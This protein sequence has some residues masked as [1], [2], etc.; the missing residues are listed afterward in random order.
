MDRFILQRQVRT[1]LT[2]YRQYGLLAL[3]RAVYNKISTF[4]RQKPIVPSQ[5]AMKSSSEQLLLCQQE[6]YRLTDFSKLE[7]SGPKITVFILGLGIYGE[8][9]EQTI[10]S[11]LNIKY[12]H[13]NAVL[14]TDDPQASSGFD[15]KFE[16]AYIGT[17]E[18]WKTILD[19]QVRDSHSEYIA[20]LQAGDNLTESSLNFV[21]LEIM[22]S[23]PEMIYSNYC[24]DER[25]AVKSNDSK[26]NWYPALSLSGEAI[27]HSLFFRKDTFQ[28]VQGEQ[29]SHLNGLFVNLT[30]SVLTARGSIRYIQQILMISKAREPLFEQ[31][32]VSQNCFEAIARSYMR[33][34][35]ADAA[36]IWQENKCQIRIRKEYNP[37]VSLI[38]YFHPKA[39]L[40]CRSINQLII[41]TEY[42]NLEYIFVVPKD[43]EE[44][45]RA[46]VCTK[47]VKIISCDASAT[48]A[49]A[50]NLAAKEANGDFLTFVYNGITCTSRDWL[51]SQIENLE[52]FTA[53]A[54]A[55]HIV[56]SFGCTPISSMTLL[57]LDE[58]EHHGDRKYAMECSEY[59]QNQLRNTLILPR[60]C[61]TLRKQVY[62]SIG[63][64]NEEKAADAYL[65]AEISLHLAKQNSLMLSDG[66]LTMT[67]PQ[68]LINLEKAETDSEFSQLLRLY[69]KQ[70]QDAGVLIGGSYRYLLNQD[71]KDDGLFWPDQPANLDCKKSILLINHELSRT[72]TPQVVLKAA[73]VLIK[74]GYFVVTASCVDGPMR[75]DFLTEG[76]PVII[77]HTLAKFRAYPPG[78]VVP[79][80]TPQVNRMLHGFDLTLVASIVGHNFVNACNGSDVKLLWWVHDGYTGFEL[81]KPYLPKQIMKNIS[82]YCG[83]AYAQKVMHEFCP[84][85]ELDSLL[86]GVEDYADKM[87]R[88]QDDSKQQLFL[89]PATFEE[90]KNQL[91]FV[92]AVSSLPHEVAKKAQYVLIGKPADD[93]YF[94]MLQKEAAGIP[95]ITISYPIPYSELMELYQKA[96]CIV[97]PSKDDPMPVVL[98]EAMM[99]SKVVICSDMTGTASYIEDGVNGFVFPFAQPEKLA[100]KV[101]YVIEKCEM[102]DELRAKARITYEQEFSEVA[103]DKRLTNII[104][105]LLN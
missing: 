64:F 2:I 76:V 18:T 12:P 46:E 88:N 20:V 105:N 53:D 83:G 19:Q 79:G 23:K 78:H 14:I 11:I 4:L 95:N 74:A 49:E 17:G 81:T 31:D 25:E 99:M 68:E 55:P 96:T 28:R 22:N 70:I 34:N 56:D 50:F 65:N 100:D 24:I 104:N 82:I 59:V 84:E 52:K 29:I 37:L 86:Y 69:G 92:R 85:Y 72:G 54:I 36:F 10:R 7:K 66:R 45:I 40:D 101:R 98:A 38:G 67:V 39:S 42:P 48:P 90:R 97:M 27:G 57:D 61:F 93:L 94:E 51:Q 26:I 13:Y 102:L 33:N 3:L 47:S 32:T 41:D 5:I 75:D 16:T 58:D 9:T 80:I 1:A 8:Y 73:R 91:A 6:L 71:A 60:Y 62:A 30:L 87:I 35:N 43:N 77:S 21:A 103:F 89:I 15:E 63:G 44:A